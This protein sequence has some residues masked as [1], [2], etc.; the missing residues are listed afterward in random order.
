MFIPQDQVQMTTASES[1]CYSREE[2]LK[3][4]FCSG[5]NLVEILPF[6]THHLGVGGQ[7]TVLWMTPLKSP[8]LGKSLQFNNP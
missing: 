1:L 8:R 7:N 2:I 4:I 3:E 5:P 6:P